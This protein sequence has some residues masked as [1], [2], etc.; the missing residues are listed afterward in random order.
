M[1]RLIISGLAALTLHALLFNLDLNG[2]NKNLPNIS[3]PKIVTLSLVR[4]EPHIAEPVR[5]KQAKRVVETTPPKK[6]QK[7]KRKKNNKK[8]KTKKEK[9]SPKTQC[10]ETRTYQTF[11]DDFFTK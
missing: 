8:Q 4:I 3:K 9:N 2:L 11:P 5:K 10:D 1:K 7:K 6:S